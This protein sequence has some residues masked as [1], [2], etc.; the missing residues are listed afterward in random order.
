MLS[1]LDRSVTYF[2]GFFLL[3]PSVAFEFVGGRAGSADSP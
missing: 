2:G 3:A 1:V